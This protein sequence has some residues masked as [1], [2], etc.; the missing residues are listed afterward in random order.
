MSVRLLRP[1]E[2]DAAAAL[3]DR[4]QVVAIPTDT[5]YGL[6]ARLAD[7]RAIDALFAV[8]QR[9]MSMPIAVLCADAAAARALAS[10]WPDAAMRLA[11]RFWPGPLTIVVSADELLEASLHS[12]RGVAVRVPDDEVCRS[13]LERCGPLAVTSANRHGAPPAASPS[14]VTEAFSEQLVAA[15]LDDGRR[16]ATV[17]TVVDLCGEMPTIV[18]HGAIP[19][20][21]VL[22]VLKEA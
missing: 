19:S 5:V 8:K 17:S 9:P 18:R 6:A 3:L 4:G 20:D 15:V 1:E 7:P 13:L 12:Q 16:G 10:A 22:A 2:I 21:S 14:E 11:A